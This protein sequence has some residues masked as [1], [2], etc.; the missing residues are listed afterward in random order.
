MSALRSS[1][2]RVLLLAALSFVGACCALAQDPLG[3]DLST[4]TDPTAP[5]AGATAEAPPQLTAEDVQRMFKEGEQAIK[6]NDYKKALTTYD[7]LIRILKQQ[8]FQAQVFLPVVYTG[9]GQAFAGLGDPEAAK[10][11]F[12]EAIKENAQHLPALVHRG[13]LYFELGANDLALADFEA[14]K[15][16]DRSNPDVMFGLGK[17]YV[18]LGGP[19]QSIKPLTY[20]IESNPESAEAYRL[21]AQANVGIGKNEKANEDIEKALSIDPDD[22]ENYFTLATVRLREEKYPEAVQAI[23]DS[24]ARY[25]PKDEAAAELPFVQ[26]YL[27]KAA[28]LLEAAKEAK[29]PEEKTAVYEKAL[30]DCDHLLKEVGD[31]P[32]Y[33]QIR[34][35]IEFRRGVVLRLMGRYGDAV[36]SLTEAINLNPELAEAYF[37]RGICFYYMGEDNLA[38]LD[39]KHAGNI[40]YQDPRPK[41]WEGFAYAK[42]GNYHEA[43]R[44]YGL[45]LG[46]SDRYVPAYVNRG[47]AYMMMGENDKAA[48]D[49]NAA[50]RLEPAEWTHYFKRGMAYERLGKRQEAADSF[51]TALRFYDK[52]PPAYRHAADNLAALGHN[53][54]AAEYRNKAAELEAQQKAEQ[55][56]A[57]KDQAAANAQ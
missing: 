12:D 40:E 2:C 33:A 44:A 6:D 19:Q 11:D 8:G 7:Q 37:R 14:A 47:L 17:A 18:L 41:L 22:F 38:I 56:K 25:K 45:A 42:L 34:S 35:A 15:E 57:Q 55:E 31:S 23:E 51:V 36:A 48:S 46:E 21:R 50:L 39:F 9:R 30:S 16:V 3:G 24:I 1:L 27:T 49:F 5:A 13:K 10:A 4:T 28:V 32:A 29:T 43:I 26:G 53:N 52:F 54:V 20:Y